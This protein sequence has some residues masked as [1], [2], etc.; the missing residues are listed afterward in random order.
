M[1]YV[2]AASTARLVEECRKALA[3]VPD[4]DFRVGSVSESGAD[5]DA[6]VLSFPLAHERY[7]G[8]PRVGVA[9]VLVNEREDDAPPIILAAP[10][11]PVVATA[12]EVSDAEVEEHVVRVLVSTRDVFLRAFPEETD[13]RIL[14]HL[15]AAGIDRRDMKP[16][17]SALRKFLSGHGVLK[18]R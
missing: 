9:Q 2:I 13:S 8:E 10:P 1:R 5:C 6:A 7:G 12:A 14:V 4:I 16:T 17:L 18:G 15:E 3:G 11:R